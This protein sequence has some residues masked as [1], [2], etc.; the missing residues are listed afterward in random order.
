MKADNNTD[1][2]ELVIPSSSSVMPTAALMQ[3]PALAQGAIAGA[4]T[5]DRETIFCYRLLGSLTS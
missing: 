3:S 1:W 5:G 4:L 2:A